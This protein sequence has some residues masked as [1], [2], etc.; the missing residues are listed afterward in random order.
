MAIEKSLTGLRLA[1]VQQTLEAFCDDINVVTDDLGDFRR[2][3]ERVVEFEK[4]SGAILSR[5]KKCNVIGFG[6]WAKRDLWPISW[7]KS[8]ECVKIFG[9]FICDSYTELLNTN[10]DFRFNKFRNAVLS[11]SSRMLSTLQQRVEVIRVFALSRVFYIAS[12]LPIKSSM[13]N[14]F[15]SLIGK[16]IWQ[17]SGKIL[18]VAIGELKN[19]HLSGGLNLPCLATMSDSLLTSQCIRLLRSGDAKSIAHMD[20]WI[21]S[22]VADLV[23][24]LGSGKRGNKDP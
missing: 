7:L 9:V 20:Y 13:V 23:L 11:W 17:G 10:W 22:L 21:G 4:F 2:L 12:I 19:D 8:V 1:S 15:E 14:K 6:N 3:E 16:F 18:R 5:N 24:G